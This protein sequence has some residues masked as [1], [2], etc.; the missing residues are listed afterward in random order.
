[1]VDKGLEG[2]DVNQNQ[3]LRLATLSGET[4]WSEKREKSGGYK[5]TSAKGRECFKISEIVNYTRRYWQQR[6]GQEHNSP[7]THPPKKKNRKEK[8]FWIMFSFRD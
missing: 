6:S 3:A 7:P 1:M 4:E 8:Q 2:G 5:V